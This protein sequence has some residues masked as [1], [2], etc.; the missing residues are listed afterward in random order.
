MSPPVLPRV[1]PALCPRLSI[2][3]RLNSYPAG[4]S[5]GLLSLGDIPYT[6]EDGRLPVELDDDRDLFWRQWNDLTLRMISD[7]EERG[8]LYPPSQFTMFR[9]RI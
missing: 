7:I 9:S 8:T 2:R 5:L 4:T 3:K 6:V 1:Y